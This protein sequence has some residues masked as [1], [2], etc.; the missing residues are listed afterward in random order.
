MIRDAEG[1]VHH[2]RI[3]V[4]VIGAAVLLDAAGGLVFAA[5]EH[6]SGWLG[7]YWAVTTATTVGYG[8]L[9]PKTP[10]GHIV[11][12]CVMLTV[13]PLFGA[14]FSLFTSGLTASHVKHSE[15][16]MRDHVTEAMAGTD[17]VD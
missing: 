2:H 17:T 6:I 5:T 16:R 1:Y 12:V 3:A 11:A 4:M 13:V 9:T 15:K 10:L 8:D 7:L 14:S